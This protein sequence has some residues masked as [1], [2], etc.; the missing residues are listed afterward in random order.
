MG[1]YPCSQISEDADKSVFEAA[2]TSLI[3][4]GDGHGT[5]WSLGHKINL[6]ARAYEGFHCHNL[7]KRA[8]QQTWDT[9]TNEA[10]GGIY[11]NLWDA[12]AP[13][14]IDGN[15]GYTA[16][17]AEMLLQ[18]YNDKLVILPALPTSF[19]Q[20]GS[21]KGLKAVGNFTVDIDW[22]NAKATQIRVV[23]NVGTPCV[24]KYTGIAKDYKVTTADGKSVKTKRIS[25]DEI[26]FPTVAGG[27]YIIV[28]KTPNAI[29]AVTG[30]Q[31]GTVATVCYYSLNGAKAN[32]T[33]S[34]GVYIKQMKYSNGTTS[35]TKV[36]N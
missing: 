9:G 14:Q 24:V 28:S 7:I 33:P 8:L 3:A 16:G 13:Y 20:K 18:S 10:A 11:E 25:D 4:R 31:E 32:S 5:G 29:A 1:L 30:S 26:S 21:V 19:W 23:S 6:N 34:H 27:K 2:R 12:H 36:I 17:V 22:D 15:F 35:T